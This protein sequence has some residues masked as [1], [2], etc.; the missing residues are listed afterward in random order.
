VAVILGLG[1]CAASVV[2]VPLEGGIGGRVYRPASAAEIRDTYRLGIGE[3]I[4]D[5]SHA[6]LAGRT[7]SVLATTGIGHL[8][9]IV[10]A[11]VEV[12]AIGHAGAGDVR[13]FGVDN[14]GNQVD[15]RIVSPGTEGGG[16]LTVRARV[17]IGQVEV[18]R[19]AA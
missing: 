14:D 9:V 11:G 19:A 5:L 3:I 16:H 2:D 18:R 1:L 13:L 7:E 4:L 15:R 6:D 12:E 10:P 8:A 17:G